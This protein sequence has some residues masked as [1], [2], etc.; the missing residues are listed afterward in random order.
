MSL[1]KSGVILVLESVASKKIL[2]RESSQTE[3]KDPIQPCK[4]EFAVPVPIIDILKCEEI[5]TLQTFFCKYVSIAP[6][7]YRLI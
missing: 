4:A 1:E 2:C 7:K 3:V 5:D 6:K